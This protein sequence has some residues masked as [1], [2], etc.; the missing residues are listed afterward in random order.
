M[1][2]NALSARRGPLRRPKVC[3]ESRNPGR[4]DPPDPPAR[5][6]CSLKAEPED[7]PLYTGEDYQLDWAGCNTG[8]PPSE[9]ITPICVADLGTIDDI[10]TAD[11]CTSGN[12]I[13][14]TAPDDPGLE[15]FWFIIIWADRGTC[16]KVVQYEI[17]DEP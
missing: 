5:Y 14:Y 12:A 2:S 17:I 1:T 9:Q 16:S 13:A 7:L 4:C 3:H 6:S 15:T 11:N 8:A 10:E